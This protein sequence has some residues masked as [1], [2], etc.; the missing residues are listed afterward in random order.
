MNLRRRS[1]D[2]LSDLVLDRI[3]AGEL[4]EATAAPHLTTC[5]SC[6]DRLAELRTAQESFVVDEL[7]VRAAQ[8]Q[9]Q[10]QEQPR[11]RRRSVVWAGSSVGAL[12][13]AAA[14]L[15]LWRP[16]PE[17]EPTVRLKGGFAL[18]LIARHRDGR[19]EQVLPGGALAPGEAIRFRVSSDEPGY[20]GVIGIDA[21]GNVTA[22]S[23]ADGLTRSLAAGRQQLLEGSIILDETL[24]PERVIAALCKKPVDVG[25]LVAAGKRA[26]AQA[27]RDPKQV[28]ELGSGCREA[29][30]LFVKRSEGN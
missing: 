20:L 4:A 19:V 21:A 5:A 17:P 7:R 3:V 26:L 10:T 15:L 30:A 11:A 28:L 29:S 22:Y 16:T 18:E 27:R 24:G 14:L 13:A 6:R 25:T 1:V 2:C 23:P 8:A 9:V 12:A